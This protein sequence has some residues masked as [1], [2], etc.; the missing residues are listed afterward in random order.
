MKAPASPCLCCG[1]RNPDNLTATLLAAPDR[2]AGRGDRVEH[3]FGA[4]RA[5]RETVQR[6]HDQARAQRRQL[7]ME[8]AG[9]F[10][11]GDEVTIQIEVEA[12]RKKDPTP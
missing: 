8:R 7:V 3:R 5:G 9:G 12:T 2:D 4:Q 10:V 11:V 1:A 6:P